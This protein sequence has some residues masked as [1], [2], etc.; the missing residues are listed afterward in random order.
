MRGCRADYLLSYY[1]VIAFV[2]SRRWQQLKAVKVKSVMK[3]MQY[4]AEG[5]TRI[6]RKDRSLKNNIHVRSAGTK[7]TTGPREVRAGGPREN[8]ESI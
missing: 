8:L 1:V 3:Y 6:S 5:I 2:A 4:E 7:V